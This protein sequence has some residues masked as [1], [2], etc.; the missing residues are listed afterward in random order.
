MFCVRPHFCL[1]LSQ[2]AYIL[3]ITYMLI[4]ACCEAINLFIY[5][6]I[7]CAL[8][9][10]RYRLLCK[11]LPFTFTRASTYFWANVVSCA[12]PD[13]RNA[14]N[15]ARRQR[16]WTVWR[17]C[18][19]DSDASVRPSAQNAIHTQAIGRYR[20]SHLEEMKEISEL[21]II[22]VFRG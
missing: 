4:V 8:L 5:F 14:Q 15:C 21:E 10:L 12:M 7:N 17:R 16:I 13:D 1:T 11:V 20:A 18:V 9:S 2:L 19:C 3:T 22:N 6:F